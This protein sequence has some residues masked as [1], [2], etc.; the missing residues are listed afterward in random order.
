MQE[1]ARLRAGASCFGSWEK[2]SRT[3]QEEGQNWTAPLEAEKPGCW[4]EC[5][6]L[7]YFEFEKV[8]VCVRA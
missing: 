7:S 3:S 6:S 5:V 1:V 2:L 8:F 4:A